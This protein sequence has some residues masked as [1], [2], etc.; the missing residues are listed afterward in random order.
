MKIGIISDCHLGSKQF[1][2]RQR[3]FDMLNTFEEGINI[4]IEN[5]VDIVL[6]SGD[7]FDS[8]TRTTARARGKSIDELMKLKD[9]NIPVYAINGNHDVPGASPTSGTDVEVLDKARLLNSLNSDSVSLNIDNTSLEIRGQDYIFE[10]GDKNVKE[11]FKNI[12]PNK[13][14]DISILMMHQSISG[15]GNIPEDIGMNLDDLPE[16]WDIIINGHHH[17]PRILYENRENKP[18]VIFPG[19]TERY[20]MNELGTKK[21]VITKIEEGSILNHNFIKLENVRDFISIDVNC[22][23]LKEKEI[24]DKVSEKISEREIKDSVTRIV[25]TGTPSSQVNI[26][27]S[28]VRKIV[29]EKNPLYSKVNDDLKTKKKKMEVNAKERMD[30]P[31]KVYIDYLK[32][33]DYPEEK[34]K[35]LAGIAE[36]IIKEL[37]EKNTD[38]ND[39]AMNLLNKMRNKKGD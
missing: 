32:N 8:A 15:I 34:A 14:T 10:R 35:K 25:L 1:K 38:S 26:D 29:K 22:E 5:E 27:K 4:L 13:D 28:K 31:E 7:L 12:T 9:K 37:E 39:L 16:E 18:T 36:Y 23:G 11:I 19:S 2:R 21:I 33:L 30:S 20:S 3:F 17:T 24:Y 6:I